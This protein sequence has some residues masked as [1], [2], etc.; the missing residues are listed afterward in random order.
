MQSV[1]DMIGGSPSI[2][3]YSFPIL[4]VENDWPRLPLDTVVRLPPKT[5]M[6]L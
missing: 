1:Y 6:P 3:P 5:A 2:S 4:L